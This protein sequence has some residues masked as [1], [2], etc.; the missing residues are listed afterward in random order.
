MIY[1]VF[2]RKTKNM[3]EQSH[4]GNQDPYARLCSPRCDHDPDE[5]KSAAIYEKIN[6]DHGPDRVK[7]AVQQDIWA[8][9]TTAAIAKKINPGDGTGVCGPS[10]GPRSG[11]NYS[12]INPHKQV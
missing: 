6:P 8:V 10:L 9:A 3:T 7:P 5:A 12:Q 1:L 2:S 11:K 4:Q